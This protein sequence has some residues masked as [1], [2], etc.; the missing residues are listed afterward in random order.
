MKKKNQIFAKKR[1]N[2]RIKDFRDRRW[3]NQSEA[4]IK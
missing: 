1:W 2:K 3:Q 4:K